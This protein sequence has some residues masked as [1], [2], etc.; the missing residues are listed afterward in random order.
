VPAVSAGLFGQTE[1]YEVA[2]VG[3][4][5]VGLGLLWALA[6]RGV[7]SLLLERRTALGGGTSGHFHG[8]LHSGARYA[9]TDPEVAAECAREG[10]LL[11]RLAPW[12]VRAC[13]G[14]YLAAGADPAYVERWLRA[15]REVGVAVRRDATGDYL[16]PDAVV[17][18]PRLLEGLAAGARQRGAAVLL[19]WAAVGWDGG[20]LR[21]EEAGSGRRRAWKVG[22]VVNCAG[23]WA[24]QVAATL[25]GHLELGLG[26][27]AMLV[28]TAGP[29]APAPRAE[30]LHRLRPPGDGDILVPWGDGTW[31]FGTTDTPTVG[32]EPG[33][34]SPGEVAVLRALAAAWLPWT[35]GR[36]PVRAFAGVRAVPGGQAGRQAPRGFAAVEHGRGL[37][38]LVGGKWTTFRAMAETM[39]QL[40]G[41]GPDRTA[42]EPIPPPDR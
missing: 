42:G 28:Y 13:G 9:V 34:A 30:V 29:A 40:L 18:A 3:G 15:C 27:G 20:E 19:G 7:P 2:V 6:L 21:A 39:V 16:V 5:V 23:P 10:R 33:P 41:L 35:R 24:G 26:R 4:G 1:R 12:A 11:A 17:D 14:R 25:G 31:V 38:S 8:L 37:Y 22:A 32:P 36:A